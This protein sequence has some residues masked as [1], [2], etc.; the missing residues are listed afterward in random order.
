MVPYI[1]PPNCERTT[2]TFIYAAHCAIVQYNTVCD[3]VDLKNKGICPDRSYGF[4][5]NLRIKKWGQLHIYI[6]LLCSLFIKHK[7]RFYTHITSYKLEQLII[8]STAANESILSPLSKQSE[9]SYSPHEIGC[10][11]T[12][13]QWLG[14][15]ILKLG[16][17]GS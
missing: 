10:P 14:L 6:Q 8:V 1:Y 7:V 16:L 3:G 2:L 12:S 15:A 5:L 4:L 9:S 11:M 17:P 13:H